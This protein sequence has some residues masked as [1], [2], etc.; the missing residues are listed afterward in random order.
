MGELLLTLG[1]ALIGA[2][3]SWPIA[4]WYY[5]R[6]AKEIPEWAR[7]TPEWAIPLIESLPSAPVSAER[8]ITLYQAALER[9]DLFPD[10]ESGYIKCPKCGAAK[11]QFESLWEPDP[12][13]GTSY[14]GIDLGYR[15][16]RCAACGNDLRRERETDLVA[17][18]VRKRGKDR[19]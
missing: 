16:R 4:H 8:L 19:R 1:G 10:P 17:E 2:L 12:H 7:N 13:R 14:M 11:S 9:G 18:F 5:R 3:L 6:A 15:V